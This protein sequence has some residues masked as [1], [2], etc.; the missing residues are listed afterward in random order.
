MICSKCSGKERN[1]IKNLFQY[2][3]HLCTAVPVTAA[4]KVTGNIFL[5]V[6]PQARQMQKG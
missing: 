2:I 3:M 4:K 5:R 6:Q 1:K